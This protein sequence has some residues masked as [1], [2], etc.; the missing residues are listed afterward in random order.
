MHVKSKIAPS[1]VTTLT[2]YATPQLST[3]LAQLPNTVGNVT[4]QPGALTLRPEEHAE[5]QLAGVQAIGWPAMKKS[6]SV[7]CAEPVF[8][9]IRIKLVDVQL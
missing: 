9:R 3:V 1:L 6:A 5:K 7:I 2:S 8:L 4:L